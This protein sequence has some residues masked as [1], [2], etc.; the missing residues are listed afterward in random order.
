MLC[1]TLH[2]S[3]KMRFIYRFMQVAQNC[4]KNKNQ[5]TYTCEPTRWKKKDQQTEVEQNP[6]RKHFIP[7]VLSSNVRP[8][9]IK[10]IADCKPQFIQIDVLMATLH[11][12]TIWTDETTLVFGE[13]P[14]VSGWWRT[15]NLKSSQLANKK[16]VRPG[17]GK[18]QGSTQNHSKR[19][20]QQHNCDL[21][22]I[23]EPKFSERKVRLAMSS[24]GTNNFVSTLKETSNSHD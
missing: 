15:P 7:S 8:A 4:S 18:I 10:V 19:N 3:H 17:K 22:F 2:S 6:T 21:K 16:C 23:A 1:I 9:D 5:E 14:A 13:L 20:L 24:A 11:C 12:V